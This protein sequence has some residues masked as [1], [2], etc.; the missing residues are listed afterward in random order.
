MNNLQYV[1]FYSKYFIV[2]IYLNYFRT[3]NSY[4]GFSTDRGGIGVFVDFETFFD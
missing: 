3:V 4:F 2:F 1:R